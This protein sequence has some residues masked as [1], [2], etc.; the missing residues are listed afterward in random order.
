MAPTVAA[1]TVQGAVAL[2][3]D[4][5]R[6]AMSM[7]GGALY[8]QNAATSAVESLLGAYAALGH[9]MAQATLTATA[10][11]EGSVNVIVEVREGPKIG[12]LTV[13]FDGLR[14]FDAREARR[15]LDAREAEQY[16]P[17]RWQVGLKR[18]S[19]A[20]AD[21]GHPLARISVR[22]VD[23][24]AADGKA[25]L[26]V[27]VDEGPEVTFEAVTYDGLGK[28][29]PGVL[30]NLTR[31]RVG[32]RFDGRKVAQARGR[33]VNSGLF[34]SVH[35]VDVLRGRDRSHVVYRPRVEEA[36]TARFMGVLGYAPPASDADTA[37]VTGLIEGVE[38]NILGTG[39]EARVR[40][41]SG[42]NRA[43]RFQ[44]REPF[45]LGRRVA[46]DLEWDAERYQGSR[47]RVA[48]GS[49]VWELGSRLTATVGAQAL[50][51]DE[52]SGSGALAALAYDTRDFRLNPTSGLLLRV[53]ADTVGGD[54]AFSR[55]VA[56]AR[57]F[58]PVRGDHSVAA[59]A[60]AARV[61]GANIPLTEWLFMGGADTLRGYEERQFRGTRRLTGS[62]E[63][64]VRTGR[65]SHVF[66][67][68]DTGR[69]SDA[70]GS[71]APKVGY[72]LGAN[73][74]SRG[75]LVRFVYGIDPSSS[76]L[77]GKVHLSLGTAL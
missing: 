36:R 1:V 17:H 10:A 53:D 26:L 20:Y 18:L 35:P 34:T 22:L 32:D 69:V 4:D 73:L 48:R 21:A 63:Y 46:L 54:I 59:R 49:L 65:L 72:G 42:E 13:R 29:R 14:R 28:T 30:A 76:P 62:L 61:G 8:D 6:A 27:E 40:W 58:M 77:D 43:N 44:Y 67:F 31:I 38:T 66:A 37:Q 9:P 15:L 33:L 51:A 64:C 45:L 16:D 3:A 57:V 41:E 68:V 11:D 5:V 56:D 23:A 39:R 19:D 25:T 55:V 71:V 2:S 70:A 52:A 12:P 60:T 50:A 7:A 75:G 47:T 74:E 24:T